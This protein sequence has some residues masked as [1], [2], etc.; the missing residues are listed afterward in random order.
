MFRR[1]YAVLLM[2]LLLLAACASGNRGESVPQG[3]AVQGDLNINI[4][5]NLIPP[6]AVYVYLVPNGGIE[7]DLGTVMSGNRTVQYRGMPLKG[8]YQLVARTGSRTIASPILVLTNVRE[9]EWDLERNFL[10]ITKIAE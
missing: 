4:R 9:I 8:T 5:N 7:R 10:Q 3:T 6:G 2:P 1:Y